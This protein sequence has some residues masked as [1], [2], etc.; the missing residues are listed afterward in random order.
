MKNIPL[1]KLVNVSNNSI[2]T[3][4]VLSTLNEK[5]TDIEKDNFQRWLTLIENEIRNIKNK[6]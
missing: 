6:K 3:N 1:Y 5:L 4:S 2:L